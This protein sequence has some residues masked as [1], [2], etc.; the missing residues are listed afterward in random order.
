MGPGGGGCV[1]QRKHSCFKPSSPGFESRLY[2]EFF[3]IVLS[4]WTLLRSNPASAKQWISQMQLVVASRARYYQNNHTHTLIG[5]GPNEKR[6]PQKLPVSTV[7]GLSLRTLFF[8]NEVKNPSLPSV[9]TDRTKLAASWAAEVDADT[10]TA[11][12]K[13]VRRRRHILR[14]HKNS[15][16]AEEPMW[17]KFVRQTSSCLTLRV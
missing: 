12:T 4:L 11:N 7:V 2:R 15:N 10:I 8:K 3:S 14:R 1:S 5:S 6:E 16:L 13:M 17:A 9:S